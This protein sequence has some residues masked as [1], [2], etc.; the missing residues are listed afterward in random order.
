MRIQYGKQ[1]ILKE[2]INAVVNV[3][4]SDFLTQGP[5][6][7]EFENAVAH[8]HNAKYAVAFANGTAS[9]HAAYSCLGVCDGDEVIS[10]PIT[11]AAT[12]NGAIYCGGVPV[13]VDI[14][15][16]TNCIA[17]DQIEQKI[18]SRTK[19]ISPIAYAGYP[20]DLKRVRDI[21]DQHNCFVLYD[22]AHAIGS[23][24]NG[25]FGMEYADVAILSFHPV[26]H[27]AAGEGGMV[28][29]NSEDLYKKLLLFRSHGITKDPTLLQRHDGPWYYEM[30]SLGYNYRITD[31]QCALAASQFKR[32][33]DNLNRRNEIASIYDSELAHEV[34]IITPPAVNTADDLHSY[35]LYT[36]AV[37]DPRDRKPLYE[38]LH[39]NGILAQVHYVPVHL[40]PY[41]KENYGY[42]E[43]DFP[44]AE[45]FYER[46]LSLPM[47]HALTMEEQEYIIDKVKKY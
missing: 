36:I 14:D 9:L 45:S 16:K 24:R 35:H 46:E 41:Y 31:I 12:T 29:T 17:I 32:I 27:I 33:D 34:K 42:A 28:L 22:A 43:G 23:R 7:S 21:A 37:R 3:L 39:E 1:Q 25:S 8:Y 6:V 47:F 5:T 4:K 2:D 26:K 44:Y 15:P 38:Y 19:V 10:A 40:H 13:F 20:V 11:F 18:S 30:Q